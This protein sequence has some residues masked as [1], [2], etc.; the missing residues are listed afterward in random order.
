MVLRTRCEGIAEEGSNNI[1]VLKI[2][3]NIFLEVH[4]HEVG[5]SCCTI[6]V[7]DLTLVQ[8]SLKMLH[9]NLQVREPLVCDEF[10]KSCV[11]RIC[12]SSNF[13][14]HRG[15]YLVYSQQM[16]TGQRP[17]SLTSDSALH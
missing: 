14:V 5:E 11:A 1:N 12:I 6:R 13:A 10:G 17:V 9:S 8:S 2:L 7:A 3:A 16:F 15:L 4:I